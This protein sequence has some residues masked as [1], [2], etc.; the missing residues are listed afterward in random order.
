MRQEEAAKTKQRNYKTELY[1]RGVLALLNELILSICVLF[2][3]VLLLI[4]RK[5]LTLVRS[6]DYKNT[7][8]ESPCNRCYIEVY[9]IY[10]K[11]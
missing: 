10:E 7:S 6:L 9:K 4:V 8:R 11:N 2:L 1:W 3:T 5:P